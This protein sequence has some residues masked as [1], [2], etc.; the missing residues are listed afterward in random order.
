NLAEFH[1]DNGNLKEAEQLCRK[2]VSLDPDFSFA[3]LTLGNICLD[4]ELVQDAVHCFK[5]FLQREKSPASKEI[6]DEVK[7]LVDGLKSEAG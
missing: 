4:Q 2:A 6:C 3:Y 7:A 5:E 1:Y